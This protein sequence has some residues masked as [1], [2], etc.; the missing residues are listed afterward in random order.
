MKKFFILIVIAVSLFTT[1]HIYGQSN[2]T[3]LEYCTGTWCQWCP[4]GDL[5]A[6]NILQ[7]RPNTLILAYHGP[8][9]PSYND[10]WKVFN[11][12]EIITLLGLNAYPTGVIGR[13]SGVQSRGAWS[14][15]V[16]VLSSYDAGVNINV[17]KSYNSGTRQLQV[18]A[19][20]TALRNIDST[21]KINLVVYEDN[22][23][24]PQVGNGSCPGSQTWVHKWVV[25]NMVNGALGED[26]STGTWTANTLKSKSWTTTLDNA[27]SA[28][29]CRVALF[30]YLS[31]SSLTSGSPVQ[32]TFKDYIIAP[33]GVGNK[34]ETATE[35]SLS[36]NYPN[37]FNPTT[38]VHFTL[39]K[40]SNV[41][42]KIFDISGR[43]VASYVNNEM[44]KAGT[45]NVEVD[46]SGWSS[47]IYFYTLQTNDF[48]ATKKMMLVK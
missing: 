9:S 34:N 41:S 35:F 29:N 27:W 32:Q 25:R 3:I 1:V 37:P 4:C 31:G 24:Y 8:N 30:V 40:E 36:Q 20:A 33:T 14:G 19:N 5:I 47:G 15:W 38:N 46:A 10:P 7:T 18:T 11:G 2:N 28:E 42:L 48:T 26:L 12:N 45:Y 16:N 6:D 21:A 39:P 23:I 22:L 43:E 13:Q 17:T 44:L